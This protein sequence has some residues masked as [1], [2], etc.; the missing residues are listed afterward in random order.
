MENRN[1]A[2]IGFEKDERAWSELKVLVDLRYK[3]R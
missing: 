3:L 1:C 2:I